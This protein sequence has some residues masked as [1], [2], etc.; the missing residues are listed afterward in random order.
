MEAVSFLRIFLKALIIIVLGAGVL[1]PT[2]MG[3]WYGDDELY[4]HS[5][6]LL[7]DPHR[8]WKAWFEPG[9]FIEYYPIEQT[10][11]WYQ[12]KLWSADLTFGY[13]ATN[14]V[15]H[16]TS[17]LM[18]WR[19]F[20]KLG[21]KLA[22][23]GGLIFAIHPMMV[24][25]VGVSCELKNTLSL[26]PFLLAMMFYLDFEE[27]GKA[28]HYLVALFFFLIAMLCKI[29]MFFFPI[30]ILLYAWWKRGDIR[31]GDWKATAPFFVISL[32][33][34]WI[35]LHAGVVY[36][37]ATHYESPGPIHLG[38]MF[39]RV[40]LC[41]ISLS[42]YLGRSFFPIDPM[43]FYP[44]FKID[45]PAPWL[46]LPWLVIVPAIACCWGRRH[47]WGRPV[48]FGF[49]F[50]VC[51]LA[52]F[53]G[54][55]EVTYMCLTWV[56]DH[57]LYLPVIAPI[58]LFI[59]G[60]ELAAKKLSRL[61]LMIGVLCLISALGLLGFQTFSYAKLFADQEQLW[62]YNLQYNPGMWAARYQL[63]SLLG[64]QG[65]L[66]EAIRQLQECVRINPDFYNAQFD[67]GLFLFNVG[68]YSESADCFKEVFRL[69]P[70]N[71]EIHAYLAEALLKAGHAAES[72]KEKEA[73]RQFDPSSDELMSTLNA[74][75]K[76]LPASI[77]KK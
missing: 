65:Q 63:G 39:S 52:P 13:L 4:L 49:A 31:R 27:S 12:W 66:D 44:L 21:L 6:P 46:F 28:R 20:S 76:P 5:N 67:L 15:L 48:F 16:L 58:G 32:L 71:G 30:T 68:R 14:L 10:I 33:L 43:P 62:R 7:K 9:S 38:G 64:R 3:T 73:A 51:G 8:L 18:L 42:F 11:Q 17:A 57:L 59:A 61:F 54:L 35:T 40:A 41:G 55:K 47:S 22:W 1:S 53:L 70:A 23:L 69:N 34:G 36:A 2:L 75:N 25:S 74:A 45:P 72:R 60:L 56:Q 24:D 37:E 19:L 50:F 26:P 29:T 77:K